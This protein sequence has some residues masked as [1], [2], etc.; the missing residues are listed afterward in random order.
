MADNKKRMP[1]GEPIVSKNMPEGDE[2]FNEWIPY[3]V[4]DITITD[5]R[6]GLGRTVTTMTDAPSFF[7][8]M[9][10]KNR[11]L[12]L[13]GKEGFEKVVIERKTKYIHN[14]K[15]EGDDETGLEH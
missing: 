12:D 7:L 6:F 1:E 13:A 15:K 3:N 14:V 10:C 9:F 4:Y 2:D 11:F 8:A 5:S